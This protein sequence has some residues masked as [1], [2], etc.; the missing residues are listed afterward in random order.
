[1]SIQNDIVELRQKRSKKTVQV[2]VFVLLVSLLFCSDFTSGLMVSILGGV[3]TY[4][5]LSLEIWDLE[6]I[7]Q[8]K[9][10]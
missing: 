2:F 4:L 1:M 6:D 3:A 8:L 10:R 5:G 7:T 9:R